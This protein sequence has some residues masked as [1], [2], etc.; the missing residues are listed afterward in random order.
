MQGRN[1]NPVQYP[2]RRF[3]QKQLM[4]FSRQLFLQKASRQT[5]DRIPNPCYNRVARKIP[6]VEAATKEN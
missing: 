4:A 6:Y 2:R 3:L 5:F 1:K